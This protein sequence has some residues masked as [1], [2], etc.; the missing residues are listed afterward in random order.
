MNIK[1]VYQSKVGWALSMQSKRARIRLKKHVNVDGTV[2][3]IHC[4][5]E[6][7]MPTTLFQSTA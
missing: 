7:I 3:G 2:T 1:D 6:I 4:H 5:R